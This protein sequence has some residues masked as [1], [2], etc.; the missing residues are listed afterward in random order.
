L[1]EVASVFADQAKPNVDGANGEQF[2]RNVLYNDL[3]KNPSGSEFA[4]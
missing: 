4:L 2:P 3:M 1:D